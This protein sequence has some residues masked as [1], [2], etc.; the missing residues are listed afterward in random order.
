[1]PAIV[2]IGI[3]L[4]A[5]RI[6]PKVNVGYLILAAEFI[7]VLFIFFWVA[8]M[9]YPPKPD[10]PNFSPYSHSLAMGIAW[11]I[12]AALFTALISRN[13]RTSFIIGLLAFSHTLLDIIAS[14][15]TAFYPADTSM[16]IFFDSSLSIGF[17]LWQYKTLA[18]ISEF[19][20]VIV[21]L[22]VYF[23]TIRKLS[24]VTK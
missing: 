22:A 7:D 6:A 9:E 8:G 3:A 1:M 23:I 15:K 4:A 12:L 16:P 5:K 13:V 11:S 10:A 18:I 20:S 14:P 24:K 19:G 17:G 2:H 21:G